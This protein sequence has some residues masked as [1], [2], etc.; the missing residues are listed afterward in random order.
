MAEFAERYH[1][2]V[3]APLFPI[4][5]LG[6]ENPDGYKYLVEDGFRYDLLLDA[7][8]SEVS[9]RTG[10][11]HERFFLYGYSG[12]AHFAHRYLLVHPQRV[13]AATIGSPGQVTLLDFSTD[14]WAGTRNVEAVFGHPM[15]VD[16]IRRVPIK[17]VVG[18]DDTNPQEIGHAPQTRYW[19]AKAHDQGATRV[20]RLKTLRRSLSESGINAELDLLPGRDHASALAPAMSSAAAFF[21]RH[22]TD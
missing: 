5:A 8:G 2:V 15:D 18:A 20:D 17:L 6:N 14:W 4:D 16:A 12:G 1:L 9:R 22:I 11:D 3:L 21:E 19:N 13:R 7:M 10:C